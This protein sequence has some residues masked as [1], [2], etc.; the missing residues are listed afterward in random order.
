VS[1]S[2]RPIP[3]AALL[4]LSW[5]LLLAAAAGCG[6]AADCAA[7]ARDPGSVE[8]GTGSVV[9]KA[10]AEGG[11]LELIQGEQ[12]GIHTWAS[13]RFTGVY[14]GVWDDPL[15][16]YNPVLQF[17]IESTE[18]PLAIYLP[19]RRPLK[20]RSDDTIEIV[21][22]AVQMLATSL[23]QAAWQTAQFTIQLEDSC[24]T[25][26]IDSRSVLLVPSCTD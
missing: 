2:L 22:E 16:T 20:V 6:P 5:L 12:G 1:R 10:L 14:P 7:A 21:G 17:T 9:F 19:Q 3:S 11:N 13:A 25:S 23:D 24:G 8:L 26:V 15:S 18:G 4:A